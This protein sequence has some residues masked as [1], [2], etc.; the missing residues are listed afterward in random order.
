MKSGKKF[1]AFVL[2]ICLICCID[3]QANAS[4][5][6]YVSCYEKKISSKVKTLSKKTTKST[7]KLKKKSSYTHT[8]T[9]SV[10]YYD[11]PIT[12]YS[13]KSKVKTERTKIKYVVKKSYYKKGSKNVKVVKTVYQKQKTAKY[14]FPQGYVKP[15]TQVGKKLPKALVTEFTD[16]GWKL[17]LDPLLNNYGD[18]YDGLCSSGDKRI[19][20][21][22]YKTNTVYHEFGHFLSYISGRAAQS[23]EWQKIYK[24]EK[25]KVSGGNKTYD[26][27]NSSEYF[28]RTFEDY[29]LHK[30]TLKKQ[31][32][33]SY[34]YINRLV[35]A[36]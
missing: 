30:K 16:G 4:D 21:R 28:A 22:T 7:K 12:T 20:I 31:R 1:C 36:L 17:V 13:K 11:N 18:Q 33:K 32:P 3:M 9:S 25:K 24:A 35:K 26:T 2:L 14:K 10:E 8:N 6:S 19:Y 27:S 15:R 29:V 23:S 5:Y 34:A